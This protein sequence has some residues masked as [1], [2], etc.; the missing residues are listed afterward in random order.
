MKETYQR[1]FLF[2]LCGDLVSYWMIRQVIFSIAWHGIGGKYNKA[3]K[4]FREAPFRDRL[5]M[6]FLSAYVPHR[7]K[8][9]R[10]WTQVKRLFLLVEI[11]L[12][13]FYA[14]IAFLRLLTEEVR[15]IVCVAILVQCFI[16]FLV[17]CFQFDSSK[18]TKYDRMR[19]RKQK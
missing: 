16:F 11:P 6:E 13:V 15:E 12:A 17:M 18:N 10:F 4:V 7:K 9:F 5:T 8:E 19:R 3:R 1:L 2:L 14:G